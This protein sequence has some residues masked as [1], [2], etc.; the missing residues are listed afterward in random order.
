MPRNNVQATGMINT[1]DAD[2][3]KL[4][5]DFFYL[6]RNQLARGIDACVKEQRY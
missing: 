2:G 4:L 5:G 6:E 1:V 3:A